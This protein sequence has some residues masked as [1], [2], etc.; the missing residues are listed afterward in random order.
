MFDS[1]SFGCCCCCRHKYII[2]D[3]PR[4]GCPFAHEKISAGHDA[5]TLFL[6]LFF[7]LSVF[8]H[9]FFPV[10]MLLLF[11][12]LVC[13]CLFRKSCSQKKCR[14]ISRC[15]FL[16]FLFIIMIIYLLDVIRY[17]SKT[18]SLYILFLDFILFFRST[19][20]CAFVSASYT[21][22]ETPYKY[23]VGVHS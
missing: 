12:S 20:V 13:C 15:F 11:F 10:S 4:G 3:G 5:L 2:D 17:A 18:A 6:L 22:V 19:Y 1:S 7:Y 14:R 21:A 8:V 9:I 23:M 16:F